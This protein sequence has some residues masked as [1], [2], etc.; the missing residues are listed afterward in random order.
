MKNTKFGPEATV[1]AKFGQDGIFTFI[2]NFWPSI[3]TDLSEPA[4]HLR[5]G[6]EKEN[7]NCEDHIMEGMSYKS[8]NVKRLCSRVKPPYNCTLS[9][10]DTLIGMRLGEMWPRYKIA[11]RKTLRASVNMTAVP[12]MFHFIPCRLGPHYRRA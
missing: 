7:K 8:S 10:G 6:R 5:L 12:P 11:R 1:Q 9:F 2:S 4:S 3:S